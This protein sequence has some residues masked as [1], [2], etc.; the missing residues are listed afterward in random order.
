MAHNMKSLVYFY[1][2]QPYFISH[3]SLI[4]HGSFSLIN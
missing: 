4:I 3:V 2:Y 1:Q